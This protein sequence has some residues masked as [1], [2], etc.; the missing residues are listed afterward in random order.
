MVLPLAAIASRCHHHGIAVLA[1]GAHA[2]GAIPLTSK[3]LEWIVHRK[4][5]QVGVGT[6]K[7]RDPVGPSFTTGRPSSPGRVLGAHQG[8]TLEFD[9]PGTR[10]PTPQLTAPAAIACMREPGV[11]A[12]QS[13]NHR[14][15]WQRGWHDGGSIGTKASG[16]GGHDRHDGERAVTSIAQLHPRRGKETERRVVISRQH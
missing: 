1:D 7:L 10:D 3:R 2:P 15:A 16:I 8:F 11:E 5:S 12:V 13:Y 4:S 6:S 9:W 14:L